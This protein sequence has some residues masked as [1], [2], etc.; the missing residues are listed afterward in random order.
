MLFIA[1]ILEKQSKIDFQMNANELYSIVKSAIIVGIFGQKIC[2][3][4][5]LFYNYTNQLLNLLICA[6]LC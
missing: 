1:Q 5:L 4:I 3:S 6:N 2:K